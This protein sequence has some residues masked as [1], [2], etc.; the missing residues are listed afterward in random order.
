[1]SSGRTT[2]R[3]R[4]RPLG[5]RLR[6]MAAGLRLRIICRDRN[7]MQSRKIFLAM[8]C[9]R[10]T[11]LL[12]IVLLCLCGS[13]CLC[14]SML[15]PAGLDEQQSMSAP[16]QTMAP[17]V[18]ATMAPATMATTLPTPTL[19]PAT[20]Q[21]LIPATTQP[22]LIPTTTQPLIPATRAWTAA[23]ATMMR[24]PSM[25]LTWVVGRVLGG[26]M[27]SP[28]NTC[29]VEIMYR[30]GARQYIDRV[31]Y[32]GKRF[33]FGGDTVLVPVDARTGRCVTQPC[34]VI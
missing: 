29:R 15:R 24:T 33:L 18:P 19:I 4:P 21:P 25:P 17:M 3:R 5:E 27:C 20:T 32:T 34:R 9:M 12:V 7:M 11:T 26:G 23:P 6:R 31:L 13:L 2:L 16:L 1:M 30:V 28:S 8:T 22:P 14:S 10:P